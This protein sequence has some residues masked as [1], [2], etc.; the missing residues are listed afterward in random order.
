MENLGAVTPNLASLVDNAKKQLMA[1]NRS[2][3]EQDAHNAAVQTVVVGFSLFE[4]LVQNIKKELMRA[5]PS[6]AEQDADALAIE[7]VI[8]TFRLFKLFAQ[9]LAAGQTDQA[10]P[11]AQ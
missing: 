9:A 6:L 3:S 4:L 5:R 7:G 11:L 1:A 8:S 2:L 10:R